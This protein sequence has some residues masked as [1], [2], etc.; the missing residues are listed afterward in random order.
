MDDYTQ[1][2]QKDRYISPN[3]PT[4]MIFEI[5]L[6]PVY[7]IDLMVCRTAITA[8]LCK[9]CYPWLAGVA[10]PISFINLPK[11]PVSR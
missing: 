7:K 4:G 9:S 6:K 11:Q 3:C 10:V 5:R 1:R 2:R 8:Y